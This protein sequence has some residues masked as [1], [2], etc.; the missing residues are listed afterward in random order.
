MKPV[1]R[2]NFTGGAAIAALSYSS[3]LG[4]N[5][6]LRM[7][8]IGLGNRGDQVHEAFLECGDAQTVAICD[9]RDDYLDLAARKSR[10]ARTRFKD[11]RRLL[12]SKDV[13][14]SGGEQA[15]VLSVPRSL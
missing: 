9:L 13:D 7:G 14:S 2:R 5:D 15:L 11:Y 6:R 1:T 12:E 3:I 8:Y 10:G 4:A